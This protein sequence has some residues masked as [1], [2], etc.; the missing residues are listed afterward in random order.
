MSELQMTAIEVP[1]QVKKNFLYGPCEH[2]NAQRFK[3][4]ADNKIIVR[5]HDCGK[6]RM[7]DDTP[8]IRFDGKGAL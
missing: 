7:F 3:S 6:S 8:Y 2:T 4:N 5:C 1:E